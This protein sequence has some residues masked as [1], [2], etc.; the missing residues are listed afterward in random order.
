[1]PDTTNQDPVSL[2]AALNRM[3]QDGMA[4]H[5]QR[6]LNA[7]AESAG[8]EIVWV[9]PASYDT[10]PAARTSRGKI[11][12]NRKRFDPEDPN[13]V[14]DMYTAVLHELGHLLYSPRRGSQ[15]LSDVKERCGYDTQRQA[16]AKKA[17]NLLEDFRNETILSSHWPTTRVW[18]T[19]LTIR[20]VLRG[21][22]APDSWLYI[23]GREYLP[24]EV[25]QAA[26]SVWAGDPAVLDAAQSIA[27]KYT[28]LRNPSLRNRKE[29]ARLIMEFAEL[30]P[31]DPPQDQQ[32]SC[33]NEDFEPDGGAEDSG[34]SKLPPP[35]QQQPK[36]QEQQPQQDQQPQQPQE[37][38]PQDQSQDQ[39]PQQ[40]QEK[41][42]QQDGDDTSQGGDESKGD[43]S[44]SK[45][46]ESKDSD[47]S[48]SES[49]EDGDSDSEEGSGDTSE[50]DQQSEGDSSDDSSEDGDSGD[51]DSDSSDSDSGNGD[52]EDSDSGDSGDS[53]EG[54]SDSGD[55]EGDAEGDSGEGSDEG[56]QSGDSSGDSSGDQSGNGEDGESE[57]SGDSSEG[58]TSQGGDQGSEGTSE[59]S[60]DTSSDGGD[61]AGSG[62]N[63]S[64]EQLLKDLLDET[65]QSKEF[66]EAREA[67]KGALDQGMN[68]KKGLLEDAVTDE[69]TRVYGR[70]PSEAHRNASRRIA[71]LMREITSRI[72]PGWDRN[73]RIGTFDVPSYIS[74]I[75][76]PRR[77]FKKYDPGQLRAVDTHVEIL[78]DQ[79]GSMGDRAKQAIEMAHTIKVACDSIKATCAVH[80]YGGKCRTMWGAEE[81]AIP[82][83]VPAYYDGGG[84]NIED[85]LI[86][87]YRNCSRRKASVKMVLI[88]TDGKY[89]DVRPGSPELEGLMK[90]VSRTG[91]RSHLF[92]LTDPYR[93][94]RQRAE[95]LRV[96][97]FTDTART[98]LSVDEVIDYFRETLVKD[99]RKVLT[100]RSNIA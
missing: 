35:P 25:M 31:L 39:Q 80:V 22:I 43:E 47:E 21:E 36:P 15:L 89:T 19:N 7:L 82:N 51:G 64:N 6:W 81:R 1:M 95:S 24:D 61:G 34:A 74:Q 58:D 87:A 29:A 9:T 17:M 76:R 4:L 46:D 71:A 84:T 77:V 12:L 99:M 56:D 5:M 49:K 73:R 16:R 41:Q 55:A 44:K 52:S 14:E 50:G 96:S 33:Q 88:L 37:Q 68:N 26:R 13:S 8:I 57:D 20:V 83:R 3:V 30:L 23:A 98:I 2:K 78:V 65:R 53:S 91:A 67:Y 45:G 38:Q 62:E 85:A 54:D 100:V 48:D 79:S 72:R 90:A 28:R 60:G 63:R 11:I 70:P 66:T 69:Q 97:C 18:F 86:E 40:P 10:M 92:F 93:S 59:N 94:T 42:E 75:Q 27:A 32:G